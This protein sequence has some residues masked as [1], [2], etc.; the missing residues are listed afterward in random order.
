LVKA[1][2]DLHA[3]S[4]SVAAGIL[5]KDLE[6]S[7]QSRADLDKEIEGLKNN[8]DSMSELGETESLRLQMAMERVSKAMTALSNVLKKNER[9]R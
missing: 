6:K 7:L 1:V 5:K 8:L 3:S 2:N 9:Y 4:V